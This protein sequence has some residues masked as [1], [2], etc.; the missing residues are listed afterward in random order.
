MIDMFEIKNKYLVILVRLIDPENWNKF[1]GDP[2]IL[3]N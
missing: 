2:N 1:S 3:N